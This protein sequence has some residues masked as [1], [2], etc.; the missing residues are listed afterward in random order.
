MEGV[1]RVTES[2]GER[3]VLNCALEKYGL[4]SPEPILMGGALD[5][6]ILEINAK[7]T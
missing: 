3:K 5:G 4:A 7:T 1:W 6:V 2:D